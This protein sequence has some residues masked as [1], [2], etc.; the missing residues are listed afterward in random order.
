MV[1]GAAESRP[2]V[3][4]YRGVRGANDLLESEAM[5]SIWE[6]PVVIATVTLAWEGFPPMFRTIGTEL[7]GATPCG[8]STF[9]CNTPATSPGTPPAYCTCALTP[10]TVAVTGCAIGVG[11]GASPGFP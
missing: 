5:A 4:M 8:T 9:T 2:V 11:A 6:V 3:R 7:P 10:P 1:S